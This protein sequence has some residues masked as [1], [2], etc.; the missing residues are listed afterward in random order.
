MAHDDS[1]NQEKSYKSIC[2]FLSMYVSAMV[3]AYT[4]FTGS[5][6]ACGL[7]AE[8]SFLRSLFPALKCVVPGPSRAPG[9]PALDLCWWLMS[10]TLLSLFKKKKCRI[11]YLPSFFIPHFE[12]GGS[13]MPFSNILVF[14]PFS[15]QCLSAETVFKQ[16]SF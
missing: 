14:F 16:H 9:N 8:R 10:L 3:A 15:I 11:Q 6:R 2:K 4:V 13:L 12:T 7:G 5:L 1:Q